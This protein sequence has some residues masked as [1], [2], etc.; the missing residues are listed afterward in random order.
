MFGTCS[1]RISV[2][3]WD[4]ESARWVTDDDP[5]DAS[6]LGKGED[7]DCVSAP[8]GPESGREI[9]FS[10]GPALSFVLRVGVADVTGGW[11]A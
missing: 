9:V 1:E 2:H 10:L 4:G 11:D 6:Q 3:S 8:D 7:A 5:V